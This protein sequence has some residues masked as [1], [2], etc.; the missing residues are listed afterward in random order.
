MSTYLV[1]FVVS[2]FVSV[3]SEED[4][5]TLSVY[6]RPEQIKNAQLALTSASK[7]LR[8]YEN[9]YD[10]PYPLHKL[11]LVAIPDFEAYAME[12]WGII[13]FREA[14][15]LYDESKPSFHAAEEIVNTV[16]HELVH[17]W[18]GNLVTMKWWDD[19]WLN[20]GFADF[21]A[22]KGIDIAKPEWKAEDHW[23]IDD[24]IDVFTTDATN[25]THAIYSKVNN[26]DEIWNLFDHITYYKGNSV[27]RMIESWLNTLAGNDENT[28]I[29]ETYFFKKIQLYLKTNKFSN[30]E[31]EELWEALESYDEEGN[32][33]IGVSKTMNG[34]IKQE[35]YPI[36]MM[37]KAINDNSTISLTQERYFLNRLQ[38][39]KENQPKDETKWTIPFS[40]MVFSNATGKPELVETK[41]IILEDKSEIHLSDLVEK[42]EDNTSIFVKGNINQN[43]YYKV[44]YDDDDIKTACEWLKTDLHF[45]EPIDRAGFLHDIGTQLFTGRTNNP[46]MILDCFNFL[47]KE[48]SYVVWATGND[49]LSFLL[50]HFNHFKDEAVVKKAH[51]FIASLIEEIYEEIGWGEKKSANTAEV[52]EDNTLHNRSKLRNSIIGL[53]TA[54]QLEKTK[55]EGLKYFNQIKNGTYKENFDDDTLK[56]V[57]AAGVMYGDEKDF[58]YVYD[59]YLKESY[60]NRKESL[61]YALTYVKDEA[62]KPKIFEIGTSGNI[63]SNDLFSFYRSF[64]S[65]KENTQLSWNFI[66]EN[67]A[68]IVEDAQNAASN[69]SKVVASIAENIDEEYLE[70]IVSW[71]LDESDPLK[72][73]FKY[74]KT[75]VLLGYEKGKS[76]IYWIENENLGGAVIKYLNEKF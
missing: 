19:L 2:K 71:F 6:S 26:P 28:D 1:A 50:R 42:Q 13:T 8:F 67:Y 12:N 27:I 43:G 11:D 33:L 46:E 29:K 48:R 18:F 74:Y 57:Y 72:E 24:V 73:S 22:Y 35:G 60:A 70:E 75:N 54:L 61:M 66:K 14:G 47:K 41:S 40:Y 5:F 65:K 37:N 23:F 30:A 63:R 62:I 9:I 21:M 68:S 56:Y 49:V 52:V 25:H 53:A 76:C 36:V 7:I 4:G 44:Q 16:A 38:L 10:I 51:N 32:P 64:A 59:R 15:I 39:L 45:M 17:Q 34:F 3:S 58:D 31:T 55:E 20:E 69:I